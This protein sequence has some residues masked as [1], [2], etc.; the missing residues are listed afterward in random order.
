LGDGLTTDA[1]LT[2]PSVG[3]GPFPGVLLVH[4]SGSTDMD[5]YLPPEISDTENGSRPFLQIAQYLSERGI[6]VLRHN[7]RGIGTRADLLFSIT[8]VNLLHPRNT[9]I[10]RFT[11]STVRVYES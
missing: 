10:S 9:Y 4:G 11:E 6:A 8:K 7:K 3:E 2:Y 5:E 1:Q